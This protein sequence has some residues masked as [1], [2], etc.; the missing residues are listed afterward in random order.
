MKKYFVI[1]TFLLSL[2]LLNAQETKINSV[3]LD[4]EKLPQIESLSPSRSNVIFADYQSVIASNTK[5]I[6]AGR[7]PEYM[8]FVYKNTENFT[9]QGLAARTCI[10][11]ET[12]ASLNQIENAQDNIKGKTFILPTVN[13]L[14]IPMDKT[15]NSIEVL[16]QENYSTQT[17]TNK[18]LC[19]N[20][21]GRN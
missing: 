13:G 10:N 7:T 9:F 15:V 8:F 2:S 16:L 20:I 12:L 6:S 18:S 14:F 5:A 11:Q 4:V 19:Y 1:F 17:L 21:D 3:K